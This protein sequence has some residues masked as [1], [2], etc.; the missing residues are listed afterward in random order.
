MAKLEE[1]VG[2]EFAKVVKGYAGLKRASDKE[3]VYKVE[4]EGKKMAWYWEG[5]MTRS[6]LDKEQPKNN[7]DMSLSEFLA[8]L[9]SLPRPGF[10]I[11]NCMSWRVLFENKA[12]KRR[13]VSR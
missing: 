12:T 9:A 10:L 5:W 8:M 13:I 11:K 7:M 3:I 4:P 1:Q 2:E 6:D